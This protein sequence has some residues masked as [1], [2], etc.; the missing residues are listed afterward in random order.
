MKYF[1]L[2]GSVSF[3]F[4]LFKP[5]VFFRLLFITLRNTFSPSWDT[6]AGL[7]AKRYGRGK[8]LPLEPY[9][10]GRFVTPLAVS[11]ST[12][13]GVSRAESIRST[14]SRG[15]LRED[16]VEVSG[17]PCGSRMSVD[18]SPVESEANDQTAQ[19]M[20]RMGQLFTVSGR[21]LRGVPPSSTSP[22]THENGAPGVII[23][24]ASRGSPLSMINLRGNMSHM[25]VDSR[26]RRRRTHTIHQTHT[27]RHLRNLGLSLSNN[28]DDEAGRPAN[29]VIWP[30]VNPSVRA[31]SFS[32]RHWSTSRS[33]PSITGKL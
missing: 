10:F 2:C 8:R 1:C 31:H 7:L 12:P 30:A 24:D 6:V 33:R 29:P 27:P 3:C 17:G 19:F 16:S 28:F 15:T 11:G 32:T 21:L 22:E 9:I 25:T 13:P 26:R 18:V 23:L 14:P 4:F 20:S 5:F